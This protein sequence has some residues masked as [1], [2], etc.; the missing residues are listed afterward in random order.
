MCGSELVSRRGARSPAGGGRERGGKQRTLG[1]VRDGHDG[2][3][4]VVLG[5]GVDVLPCRRGRVKADH[6]CL[7][8]G[9]RSPAGGESAVGNN[10]YCTRTALD[11][12]L[13]KG[14]GGPRLLSIIR[15]DT[16]LVVPRTFRPDIPEAEGAGGR[17][18]RVDYGYI[19][20]KN[21]PFDFSHDLS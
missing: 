9:A 17:F 10:D 6:C 15:G 14:G 1:L 12:E 4:A 20:C 5:H 3:R 2:V 7:R 16:L 19:L 13:L 18:S 11:V 8:R 21:G